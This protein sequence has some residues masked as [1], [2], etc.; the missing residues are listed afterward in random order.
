MGRRADSESANLGSSPSDAASMRT[1]QRK[2][3]TAVA[4]AIHTFT[5]LGYDVSK[6][7]TESA[8]Y[9]LVVDV[10]NILYRLQVKFTSSRNVDLRRIHSNSKGYVIKKNLN[11]DF[12]WLYV[13]DKDGK[14]Y[15]FTGGVAS[16]NYVCLKEE[17]LLE[18]WVRG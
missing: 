7:I 5:S 18:S 16:K 4:K 11:T 9:D 3:D 12:D 17:F 15:L 13:L 6:P 8:S 14:E 2:G 1:T 10:E